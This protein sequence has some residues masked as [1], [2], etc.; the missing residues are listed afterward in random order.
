MSK[1]VQNNLP[2]QI[3]EPPNRRILIVDDN[4]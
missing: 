1:R 4:P 3:Q 2:E